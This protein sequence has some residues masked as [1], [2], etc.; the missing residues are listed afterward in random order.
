VLSGLF[1]RD[2]EAFAPV[3]IGFTGAVLH[4]PK[5]ASLLV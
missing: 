1:C 3:K 4:R 5:A 2:A